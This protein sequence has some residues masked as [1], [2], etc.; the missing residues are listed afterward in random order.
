MD[1]GQLF[2]GSILGY[3]LRSIQEDNRQSYRTVEDANQI[4]V[5]QTDPLLDVI[6][7]TIEQ[8]RRVLQRRMEGFVEVLIEN[9]GGHFES[10]R[11]PLPEDGDLPPEE[12]VID[13][14]PEPGA[15]G[16][17]RR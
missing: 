3:T 11:V 17:R 4:P 1:I 6:E 13:V 14:R 16:F 8:G 2:L 10:T 5:G 15:A 7:Q 12:V 9:A